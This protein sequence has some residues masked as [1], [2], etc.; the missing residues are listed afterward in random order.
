MD[1]NHHVKKMIA[2]IIV[3]IIILSYYIVSAD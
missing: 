1:K 3:T 2:P